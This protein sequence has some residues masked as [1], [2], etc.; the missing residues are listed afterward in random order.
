MNLHSVELALNFFPRIVGVREGRVRFDL[1]PDQV[2]PALLEDLYAGDRD[3]ETQ[4]E[5]LRHG[6][7]P[8]GRACRPLPGFGG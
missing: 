5:R 4:L 2:T 3:D 8:F 7:S 6:Y 1:P